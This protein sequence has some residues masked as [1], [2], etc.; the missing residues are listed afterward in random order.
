[1]PPLSITLVTNLRSL[2]VALLLTATFAQPASAQQVASET[3][4]EELALTGLSRSFDH[5]WMRYRDAE[6]QGQTELMERILT[7]IRRLRVERN[8]FHLHDIALAFAYKGR[9]YLEQGDLARAKANFETAA[10][11]DPAL[12]TA[13]F[14]LARVARR[15]D[16]FLSLDAPAYV[17]DG[18]LA[19]LHS[20]WDGY[21]V[22]ADLLIVA[23]LSLLGVAGFLAGLML[24]RYAVLLHHDFA[25]RFEERL[26][27]SVVGGVTVF[28]LVLPLI[29]TVGVGWLIPYWLVL[30]FANQSRKERALSIGVLL[31]FFFLG[32]LV[33]LHALW[34]RTLVNPVFRAAMSSDTG[35]FGASDVLVLQDALQQHP[36]DR[37]LTLVLATQY[38]NLGEYDL[39]A[40]LYREL[41]QKNPT[42]LAAQVNL[43]NIYFAQRDFEGAVL[44][45]TN[46][47]ANHS[48]EALLY[49]NMS[50][51]HGES[52]HFRERE[53]ARTRADNLD[54]R[55]VADYERK[56]GSLRAV[57]D[58]KLGPSEILT[59]FFGREQ[60]LHPSPPPSVTFASLLGGRAAGFSMGV[61]L[62]A[63]LLVALELGFRQR[64]DTQRC[65]KCGSPFCGRC[66]IGTGRRGLCTQCYHLFIVKDGVSAGA[67]NQKL[68]QVTNDVRTRERV[69]RFLSVVA[70]GAGHIGEEMPFIGSVLLS[71]WVAG[72]LFF[73]GRAGL[74]PLYPMT[75]PL[76]GLGSPLHVYL[77]SAVLIGV[78]LVAN[79]VAQPRIRT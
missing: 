4:A 10:E 3:L 78:F 65:T 68:A 56:T 43:G 30:T 55:A 12:P 26:G 53:E 79:V 58:L 38:K 32:P 75:A 34:S 59:K 15:A 25:E 67:R 8:T 48:N 33:E 1:M 29:A 24:Y 64:P 52:F 62:L 13:F 11:L 27:R 70:P 42:D 36:D 46:A 69:F 20:I 14:G 16:G 61:L 72:I 47:L 45:Y 71:L 22:R 37:E 9:V 5:L 50:L 7:E 54:R 74:Y 51:A 6:A 44:Q 57:A 49:Y 35:T 41:L 23:V 63:G 40:S 28:V 2:S 73:W 18:Y 31:F 60:G 21:Y 76:M 66:Q 19:G 17:I 77:V 39:S